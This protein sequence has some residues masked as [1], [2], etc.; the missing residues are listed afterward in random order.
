MTTIRK[1]IT[2]HAPVD[3]VFAY[4]NDPEHLPEIWPSMVEVKNAKHTPDGAHSFDWTYKMAGLRFHGHSDT[5][6]TKPN[7]HVVVK[8]EG[9]IPSTFR[10]N[11]LGK[12]TD[13]TVSLEVEY[14]IPGSALNKL[15]RPFLTKI[16]EREAEHL[17]ENL[18][19]RMEL[20]A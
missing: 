9:G 12:G 7:D 13:T 18:K 16:N 15:A 2:I 1:S 10:W 17:L 20:K 8:N 5:I 3:Q 19:S 11:Y 14:D 4:V 6:D